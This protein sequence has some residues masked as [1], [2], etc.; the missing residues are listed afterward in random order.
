MEKK[1]I[2]RNGLIDIMRLLFAGLV[3]MYHFYNNGKKHFHGGYL[4]VEFFVIL[5]GF[6][7]FSAW[8]QKGGTLLPVE[9]RQCYLLDY[10]KKRYVRFFWYSFVAFIFAFLIVRVWHEG[11]CDIAGISDKLSGDIWEILLVKMFGLNRGENVLNAPA[12][13]LSCMLFAEFFILGMLVFLERPFLLFLMPLSMIF[14]SGYW[15]N[16]DDLNFV[17]FHTFFT[18]GMLRVYLLTCFGICTYFICKKLKSI[19]FSKTGREIL[20]V[21]E[22]IGYGLCIGI[23]YFKNSRNYRFCFILIAMFTLALSFSGK[24]LAGSMLPANKFTNFCAEFS[25]SLYLTSYIVLKIFRYIYKDV[26][27]LY[28]QKFLFLFCVIVV[29]MAYTF[30]MRGVFKM[31]PVIKQKLESLMLE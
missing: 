21:V 7:F 4:G 11:I 31:L 20:T 22:L 30:I 19:S 18:L 24:S 28:R 8:V 5:A 3:M 2:Q 6:L 15:M 1:M 27:N 25:L 9:K 23:A 17:L 12:W 13:T 26:N 10:M 14:G 29:A 16:V